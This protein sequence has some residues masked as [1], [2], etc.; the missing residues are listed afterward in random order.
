MTDIVS[1]DPYADLPED[2][3]LAFLHLEEYFR[4]ECDRKI[5]NTGGNER[6]D[7]IYVDY[8]AQ[9][10]GAISALELEAEFH[11]KVPPIEEVDFNTYLN[12]NKDVKNYCTILK[13]RGARRAQGF[14][15]QFDETAKRKIHH[16]LD[17]VSEIFRK[18]E[19]EERQREDLFSC[20]T[21]LQ[22]EVSR[23]RT[24]YDRLAALSIA[25]A[26]VVGEVAEKS[27]VL[28]LLDAIARIFWG[29]QAESPKRLPPPSETKKLP[30]P[31]VVTKPKRGDMDDEIPF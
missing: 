22:K 30:A 17:K 13:I 27:K 12:F 15:V 24:H 28:E 29:A 1:S 26:G 23:K 16:H 3:E 2:P 14:S 19:I 25:T 4:A 18:L 9:V 5:A 6:T 11:S 31:K 8:I 20:L 7:I 10:L 21:A